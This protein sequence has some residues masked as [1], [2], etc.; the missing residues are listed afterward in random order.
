MPRL[1]TPLQYEPSIEGLNDIR[2][3]QLADEGKIVI[4][5]PV[6]CQNPPT[7][8]KPAVGRFARCSQ[9]GALLKSMPEGVKNYLYTQ[10]SLSNLDPNKSFAFDRRIYG[11][12]IYYTFVYATGAVIWT[13]ETYIQYYVI[14]FATTAT[15]LP[16]VGTDIHFTSSGATTYEIR[17]D[18]Y[19][20]Y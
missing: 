5:M 14:I 19:G 2:P 20:F 9:Q 12:V 17:V 4:P 3:L 8:D 11:C 16:F 7:K 6:L 13:D 15:F 18:F 1:A 10:F